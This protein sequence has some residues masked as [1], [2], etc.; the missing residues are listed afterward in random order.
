M[1]IVTAK[2]SWGSANSNTVISRAC[3]EHT[4]TEVGIIDD[5]TEVEQNS[6]WISSVSVVTAE[7]SQ[8]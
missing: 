5:D 7:L 6:I 1:S 3:K 8:Q 4:Q 2:L